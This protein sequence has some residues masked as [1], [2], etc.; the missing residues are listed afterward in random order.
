MENKVFKEITEK[1]R[2]EIEK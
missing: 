2:D 1:Q